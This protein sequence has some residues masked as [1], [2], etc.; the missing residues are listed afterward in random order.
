MHWLP[1]AAACPLA[2]APAHVQS[3]LPFPR[4][5]CSVET[6]RTR[7]SETKIIRDGASGKVLLTA[8]ARGLRRRSWKVRG[9]RAAV[10]QGLSPISRRHNTCLTPQH[11]PPACTWAVEGPQ[12]A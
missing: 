11:Y 8:H 5:L 3:A 9:R 1:P 12:G 4:T 6:Y 10:L 7:F 2:P